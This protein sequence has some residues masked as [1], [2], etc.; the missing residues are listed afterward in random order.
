MVVFGLFIPSGATQ[1]HAAGSI[2]GS[3]TLKCPVNISD[4]DFLEWNDMVY[5]TG[6]DPA[7]I[8]DSERGQN[9]K[10]LNADFMSV[11]NN[12][13]TIKNLKEEDVGDYSCQ[14]IGEDGTAQIFT[15]TLNLYGKL[16]CS[17]NG[18]VKENTMV[19]L[20]CTAEVYGDLPDTVWKNKRGVLSQDIV[21]NKGD[22]VNP[23]LLE[24]SFE[25][26]YLDD[27][28]NY[29]CVMSFM[30]NQE[31]V[32]DTCH[33]PFVVTYAARD[34]K[35]EPDQEVYKPGDVLTFSALGNPQ[36]QTELDPEGTLNEDGSISIKITEEMLGNNNTMT[37]SAQNAL[38]NEPVTL[39]K[40]FQVQFPPTTTPQPEPVIGTESNNNV[41]SGCPK[42]KSLSAALFIFSC[43]IARLLLV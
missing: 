12:E 34:P 25:A 17:G 8:Y 43:V 1:R 40:S 21:K 6:R 16:S 20:E 28:D 13:L 9:S 29:T 26:S 4:G 32:T 30:N 24:A 41:D 11:E 15:F 18:D 37:F 19:S 38:N 33:V 23:L 27:G 42:M 2:D 35:V 5:N 7:V 36:P 39:Q 31:N 14:V 10:H 3:V 22:F